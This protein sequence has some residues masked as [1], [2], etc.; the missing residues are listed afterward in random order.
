MFNIEVSYETV[1]P[2]GNT[3]HVEA[4][5]QYLKKELQHVLIH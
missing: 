2:A 5:F 3:E 1:I 4:L